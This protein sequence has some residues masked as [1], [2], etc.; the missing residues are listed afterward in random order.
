MLTRHL[1]PTSG[2]AFIG[3]NSILS[4]FSKASTNLGVV[5]QTNSLW[6][7]LSVEDHLFLFARLRGVPEDLVKKVVDGTIDQLELTPHRKKLSQR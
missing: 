7:L 3:S 4:E 5:T 6:D 2:D 1:I